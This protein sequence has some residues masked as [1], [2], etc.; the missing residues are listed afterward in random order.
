MEKR[1]NSKNP[2]KNLLPDTARR[3]ERKAKDT[4]GKKRK[5]KK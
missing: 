1:S 3:K 2:E 5:R 4:R